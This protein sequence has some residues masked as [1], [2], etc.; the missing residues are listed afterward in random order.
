ML[1]LALIISV[2]LVVGL[3]MLRYLDGA[4]RFK[5]RFVKTRPKIKLTDKVKLRFI[6]GDYDEY[7]V[8]FYNPY[9]RAWWALSEAN[10]GIHDWWSF[11]Y[12]GSY[13]AYNSGTFKTKFD[14]ISYVKLEFQT[15]SDIQSHFDKSNKD[16][17]QWEAY[18]KRQQ[19]LPKVI[20]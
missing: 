20:Y 14:H 17:D 11:K 7:E 2:A 8:Q 6:K 15:L 13:G 10:N 16:Y 12:K 9:K 18:K 19:E 4:V 5:S 1:I 3:C